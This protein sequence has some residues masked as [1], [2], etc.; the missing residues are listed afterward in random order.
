MF[1]STMMISILF[2][3]TNKLDFVS[4][5]LSQ[6]LIIF[7]SI[8]FFLELNHGNHAQLYLT[9]NHHP[10]LLPSVISGILI[11]IL[12]YFLINDFGIIGL[13][14]SQGFVQLGFN[15][16]Y[17]IYLNIKDLKTAKIF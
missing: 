11:L 8:I 6:E 15:N 5:F 1:L 17:P 2:L 14:I 7:M 12:S 4:P 3:V 16:W 9:N 13:L 10:F